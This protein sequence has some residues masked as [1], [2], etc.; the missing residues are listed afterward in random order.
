MNENTQITHVAIKYDGKVYSL[1]KPNRHHNVIRM[2]AKENG[3]GIKGADL[4]GF[5]DDQGTFLNRRKA[6]A[7]ACV[8][9]QLSRRPDGYQ[10]LEL[11]SED[12][13]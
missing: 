10:G 1:P 11:Y 7:L 3:V 4:Q 13:W 2:I 9:G 8:N 5:L 12:L 6:Y